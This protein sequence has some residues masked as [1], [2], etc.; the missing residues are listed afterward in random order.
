MK[1]NIGMKAILIGLSVL[2]LTGLTGCTEIKPDVPEDGKYSTQTAMSA[3]E[4]SIYM[5]KQITV[6][7]N[8]LTTRMNMARS[9]G[10]YENEVS[11]TEQSIKIMKDVLDEVKVTMPSKGRDDD[12]E[13]V[14][15]AMQTAINHMNSYL[16]DLENNQDVTGYAQIFQTDF[17]AL[18]GLAN[19]Y[20]E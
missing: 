14:I 4:Y 13:T 18:T 6:Y 19:L 1:K 10:T 20:Y 17:N 15:E 8:Q 2:S 3:V 9:N 12:R 16:T 5:N 7:T 11:Q